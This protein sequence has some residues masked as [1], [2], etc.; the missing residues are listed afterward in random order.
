VGG[1]YDRL[2]EFLDFTVEQ[3]F[4]KPEHRGAILVTDDLDGLLD[5]LRS[6]EFVRSAKWIGL[7]ES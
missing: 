3:Q 6:H 7:S 1:Y 2:V 5:R 4:V